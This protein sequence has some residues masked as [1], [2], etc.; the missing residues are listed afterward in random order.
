[1]WLRQHI[2]H[3]V[4]ALH[5]ETVCIQPAA[6]HVLALSPVLAGA[7]SRSLALQQLVFGGHRSCVVFSKLVTT[8]QRKMSVHECNSKILQTYGTHLL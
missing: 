1:M 3:H 5:V 6:H 4:D 8:S 7:D 2:W